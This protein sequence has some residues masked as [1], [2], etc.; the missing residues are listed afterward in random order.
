M[1]YDSF[2]YSYSYAGCPEFPRCYEEKK[3]SCKPKPKC[4]CVKTYACPDPC[5]KKCKCKCECKCE[6]KKEVKVCLPQ[7]P[8][9]SYGY[10]KH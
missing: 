7:R 10:S 9:C 4:S 5:K 3:C 2:D 8:H 6:C 1:G